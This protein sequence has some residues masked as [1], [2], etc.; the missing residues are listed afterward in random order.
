MGISSLSS[1]LLLQSIPSS[2]L[3]VGMECTVYVVLGL[4]CVIISSVVFVKGGG[5]SSIGDSSVTPA[6]DRRVASAVAPI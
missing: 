2:R 6:P 5:C 3:V 1:E 4:K